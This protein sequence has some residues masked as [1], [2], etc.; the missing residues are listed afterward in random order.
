MTTTTNS[1]NYVDF[2][3]YVGLKLEKTRSTIRTTDLL[4][5]LAGIAAMFLGYL[6]IFVAFDQ[7][8]IPGGF[9]VVARWILL[10]TLVIST[11][12]WL[13]WK[14]GI[15]SFRTVNGL[16]A[17]QEIEKAEP[18][19]KSNLLNLIDL[20]TA[21]R[22]VNPVILKSMERQAAV[23]LQQIDIAQAIDHRP[24]VRT[25][26]A[27]LA[28]IVIFCIYV[29]L[30]P[31][32]ISNSI[33]RGLLPAAQVPLATITEIVDVKP[34][35]V[36]IPAHQ[37]LVDIK[38]DLGGEIP[39][40]V[41]LLYSTADGKH[42]QPIELRP[43]QEG[44]T[45]FK[46]Q[47]IG[48]GRQGLMQDLTYFIRA[49]DATSK[50][51]KITVE[52]PPYAEIEN[53]QIEFP[54]YMKLQ[55]VQQINNGAIDA[56]EGASVVV[57]AKTNM[58]V[59][60]ASIQF[61]DDPQ[62]GPT[63]EEVTMSASSNG[64]QLRAQWTLALR[65]DGTFPKYY[66]IHCRTEEGRVTTGHVIYPVT[67][68]P[69]LP[70]EVLLLQPDRDLEAAENATIPLLIQA[71]DPDFELGYIYLNVERNGQKVLHEQLSE[72]RL[73]KLILK[74]D[75][76]LKRLSAAAG[77]V[78][79]LWIEAYD[80]K[81]PRPNSK[82]SPKIKIRVVQPVTPNE[83]AKQL[84]EENERRDQKL[85][86]ADQEVNQEPADAVPPDEDEPRQRPSRNNARP[87]DEPQEPPENPQGNPPE[88][89]Q[90]G[91][92][93]SKNAIPSKNTREKNDP[94]DQGSSSDGSKK[95]GT[96]KNGNESPED[97][98]HDALESKKPPKN[99]GSDDDEIIRRINEKIKRDNQA[100]S[101]SSNHQPESETPKTETPDQPK[102]SR[103]PAKNPQPQES[104]DKT[105][106]GGMNGPTPSR[107]DD[108]A[109]EDTDNRPG[110]QSQ[111]DSPKVPTAK[112]SEKPNEPGEKDGSQQ[113]PGSPLKDRQ[114]D[115][116]QT[117]GKDKQDASREQKTDGGKPDS[118]QEQK[119]GQPGDDQRSPKNAEKDDSQSPSGQSPSDPSKQDL[120]TGM[121]KQSPKPSS[122]EPKGG[123]PSK[124]A[125]SESKIDPNQP[126][127]P[128]ADSPGSQKKSADGTE[129]G[130][131]TPDH[132]ATSDPAMTT[133]DKIESDSS[134]TPEIRTE[135]SSSKPAVADKTES[136]KTEKK[137]KP[138]S[139]GDP[140][141]KAP[142]TGDVQDSKDKM[143]Q[144]VDG[145]QSKNERTGEKE[146]QAPGNAQETSEAGE[147]S[148]KLDESSDPQSPNGN[149]SKK[150]EPP[151]NGKKTGSDAPSDSDSGEMKKGDPQ[152]DGDA[153]DPGTPKE[154]SSAENSRDKLSGEKKPSDKKPD[155]LRN[156]SDSK[157]KS[158]PK[159][160]S[161]DKGSQKSQ[162]GDQGKGQQ[163]EGKKK[164]KGEQGKGDQGKG[165]Q[166]EGDQGKGEQ[167]QGQGKG[168][169]PSSKPGTQNS[170]NGMSGPS[171]PGGAEP[172]QGGGTVDAGQSEEANFEYNRRATELILQK[173][174][175]DLERGETDP[176][177]LEQ[178]GWSP[179]EM[180]RFADR[181]SRS[182]SESKLAE[183][184]AE[185][186]ARQQQFQEML[187]NLDLQKSGAQRTGEQEPKRDLDQIE[188][189]RMPPPKVYGRAFDKFTKELA[190]Q[191]KLSGE[192]STK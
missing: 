97:R 177:L 50:Q 41:W 131:G 7:W 58:P 144:P 65:S 32:K 113:N 105:N 66:R 132:D 59:R 71:R 36:T 110:D 150:K 86:N 157:D 182:L 191:K 123:S 176:E 52:Q 118:K 89:G 108:A 146:R 141:R 172:T 124:Q 94:K 39:H 173:L 122:S 147:Q 3:E 139:S 83:A 43:D 2:D 80:N 69:D 11:I 74:H 8:V 119:S 168:S 26:Y 163:G 75:L 128:V 149:D 129:H 85:A 27:L 4:T 81:Q 87:A 112:S 49:G 156:A 107:P 109:P 47:L 185:T 33:W 125:E 22:T 138:N 192:K 53:I 54:G 12:A 61:L 161:A 64:N 187:K 189:K 67:I 6:L 95:A 120:P 190:R 72:G 160:N 14:I 48:D 92:E 166:G 21:G 167:G 180:K 111:P 169:E 35:N 171:G 62:A 154:D 38:V 159:G 181:L 34:G 158:E 148:R 170:P 68:R 183:A 20:K 9:G 93:K 102:P 56:W 42:D 24:L 44:Q 184:P 145:P 188:S 1:G 164:G 179:E 79:E 82:N 127:E 29:M 152:P 137:T 23:R 165:E 37:P 91:S 130:T 140:S 96:S 88:N 153:Q 98:G 162:K 31:K 135:D 40:Q 133:G 116:E 70:P 51:F 100:K 28:V 45:C 46:G 175:D 17:A 57:T 13:V 76:E 55:S 126:K 134:K 90:Q 151:N 136:D 117:Q 25:A 103:E 115:P 60:S 15:P 77:E 99:D 121:N 174:K 5:A 104:S 178:L 84:A 186:K 114:G 73:S 16:F 143:K 19:F 155:G 78:I 142:T 106:D 63:G 18:K 10:S 30:S 101:E